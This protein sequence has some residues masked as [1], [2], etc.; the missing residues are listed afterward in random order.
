MING[1]K[2]KVLSTTPKDILTTAT[3]TGGVAA[4][5]GVA[6]V[7]DKYVFDYTLGFKST[8]KNKD[9]LLRGAAVGFLFGLP[10]VYYNIINKKSS[11]MGGVHSAFKHATVND[12]TR[13]R[14]YATQRHTHRVPPPK[15]YV[16]TVDEVGR[17]I[18]ILDPNTGL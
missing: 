3:I 17:Q 10:L 11:S 1:I 13:V 2:E 6:T 7:I 9:V 4:V 18:L 8:R 12:R 16:Y 14:D 5:T 15:N